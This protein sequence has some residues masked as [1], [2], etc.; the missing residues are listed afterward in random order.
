MRKTSMNKRSLEKLRTDRRLA[1]RRGWMSR[2]DL[3]RE[4]EDL[5]DASEKIAEEE[6]ETNPDE[7]DAMPPEADPQV[8]SSIDTA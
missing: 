5:P 4:A 1:G 6:P 3:A 7:I 8:P 2:V